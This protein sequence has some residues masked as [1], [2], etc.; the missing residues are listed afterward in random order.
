MHVGNDGASGERS[1]TCFGGPHPVADQVCRLLDRGR[2]G[3]RQRCA[4]KLERLRRWVDEQVTGKHPLTVELFSEGL[5]EIPMASRQAAL[6]L[7]AEP[8]G[9]LVLPAPGASEARPG[10]LLRLASS[11]SRTIGEFQASVGSALDDAVIEPHEV[12]SVLT[13]IYAAREA[14]NEAER[15]L[16][17]GAR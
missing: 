17:R 15:A 6:A 9:L 11:V 14:L 5:H 16:L 4:D 8:V 10:G 2:S 3:W 7:L 1:A 13:T 12:S